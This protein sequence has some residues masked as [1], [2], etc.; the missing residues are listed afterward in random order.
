M[1]LAGD[2]W[3]WLPAQSRQSRYPTPKK[4]EYAGP[5]EV[6]QLEPHRPEHTGEQLINPVTS[7]AWTWISLLQ[8][9]SC[10]AVRQSHTIR[11]PSASSSALGASA[12]AEPVGKTDGL[13]CGCWC[14]CLLWLKKEAKMLW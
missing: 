2:P 8:A 5:P 12:A 14:F 9:V 11:F 6:E 1:P 10:V 7:Q 13:T 4:I 3:T